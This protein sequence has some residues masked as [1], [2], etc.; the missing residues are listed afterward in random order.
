MRPCVECGSTANGFYRDKKSPDGLFSK[1]RKCV[2]RRNHEWKLAHPERTKEIQKQADTRRPLGRKKA[3]DG[4]YQRP[5][6]KARKAAYYQAHKKEFQI[7]LARW[8]GRRRSTDDGSV[9]LESVSILYEQQKGKCAH[10]KKPLSGG[11]HIDHVLPLS[12]D[13][14]HTISNIQLLCEFCNLSKNNH[15]APKGRQAILF[16]L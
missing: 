16:G 5:E 11:F 4:Y 10:C 13:G 12:K 3:R 15:A 9:T 7:R 14:A 2:N 6:W 1:C 8:Y